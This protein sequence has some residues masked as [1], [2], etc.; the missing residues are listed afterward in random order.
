MHKVPGDTYFPLNVTSRQ[1]C[2]IVQ[3]ADDRE[4]DKVTKDLMIFRVKK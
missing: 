2:K 1:K 4:I 3:A